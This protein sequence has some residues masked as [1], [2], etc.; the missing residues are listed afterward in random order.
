[1]TVT[2]RSFAKINLGLRIGAARHDGFHE[3]LTVYQTIG[4]QDLIKVSLERGP[5]IESSCADARVPTDE[6]NT[7]YR[8][9]E[10][11]RTFLRVR[12]RVVIEIEKWLPVQGGLGGASANAVT[13]LLG[14]QKAANKSL[15]GEQQLQLAAGGGSG[16]PVFLIRGLGVGRGERVLP[17]QELPPTACVIVTPEVGVSTPEAFAAWDEKFGQEYAVRGNEK[18][19][20]GIASNRMTEFCHEYSA[21]L[22]LPYSGAPVSAVKKGSRAENPLLELVRA[23]IVND[24]ERV[25]FP[26]H[27]ELCEAKHALQRAGADYAS[28][29]GSGSALYGL[30]TSADKAERAALRLRKKGWPSH[31]TVTLTRDQYWKRIFV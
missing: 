23:G 1:M 22:N 26:E 7:C 15:P 10:R 14:F 21:W 17:L 11:A 13:A 3:L 31:A 2:L 27:P 25:V 5:G 9:V 20:L 12:G 28:L 29:S 30:F 16:M 24:F 4:L 8:M 18:L 19:T 6:S